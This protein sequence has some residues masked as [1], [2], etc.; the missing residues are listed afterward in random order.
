[1][2]AVAIPANTTATVFVPAK[3]A[4]SVTEGG[5]PL[6]KSPGVEFLRFED[7]AVV[8]NLQSGSYTFESR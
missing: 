6:D 7:G 4:A 8:L 5:R 3:D 2:Y 1:M